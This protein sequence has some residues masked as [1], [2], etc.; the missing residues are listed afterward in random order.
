[1]HLE[2]NHIAVPSRYEIPDN[3]G[4]MTQAGDVFYSDPNRIVWY[5]HAEI[6]EDDTKVGAFDATEAFVSPVENTS[7]LDGWG[8]KIVI[9][10]DG[11][12]NK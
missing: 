3:S 1:M 4:R 5:Y 10:S 8:N 7:V 12:R 2:D 9:I 11:E 6:S